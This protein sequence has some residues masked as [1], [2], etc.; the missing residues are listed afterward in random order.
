MRN[1]EENHAKHPKIP[2]IRQQQALQG[3]HQQHTRAAAIPQ[4]S[5]NIN[6]NGGSLTK[7][8]KSKLPP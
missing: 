8:Q 3:Q 7:G 5:S 6:K 4:Q 1:K 2:K